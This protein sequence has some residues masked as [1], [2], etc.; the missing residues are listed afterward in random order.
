MLKVY[1]INY[2]GYEGI[3]IKL[4]TGRACIIFSMGVLFKCNQVGC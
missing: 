1:H 4:F 2:L 3:G